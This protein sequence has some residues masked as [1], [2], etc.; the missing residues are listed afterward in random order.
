M[1]QEIEIRLS[2]HPDDLGKLAASALVRR[3]AQG[4]ATTRRLSTLYYDTP[5]FAFA[6]RGV[7]LRVRRQGKRFIQ[8]VKEKNAGA[9]LSERNEWE[10]PLPDARPDL[11]F[12]PDPDARER[13]MA[14][15]GEEI[16]EPKME[17]EIRRTTRRLK[18]DT[19]DEIE[20]AID[21][22]E[23]R[24]FANGGETLAISEIELELKGGSPLAL[25]DVVRALSESAALTVATESKSER[26]LRAIEGRKVAAVKA[27]RVTLAADATAEDAFRA[28]LLHCLRPIVQNVPAVAE[29]RSVE[30]LHQLRVGLRRL[31]AGFGAFG[32]AFENPVMQDLKQRAAEFARGFGETRDLD[33]FAVGLFLEIEDCAKGRVGI[34]E[35]R[36]HLD[37]LREQSWN[38]TAARAGSEAFTRFL[39]DLAAAAEAR[40]WREPADAA[41][42]V[43]FARPARDFA[44]EALDKRSRKARKRAK[45]LARLTTN[46][47][48]RLRIALK[49]LRYA[50][51]FFASLFPPKAVHIYQ[52]K[53]SD[54]QDVFG[55]LNDA[56]TAEDILRRILMRGM[57]E[58]DFALREGAAFTAGWHEARIG[59]AWKDARRRW[60]QLAKTEPFWAD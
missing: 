58:E 19:G 31:R 5:D 40:L 34:G 15:A 4:S 30:G 48:H 56:A 51:D 44:R 33:V 22:G 1:S 16:I 47:R 42:I 28:M 3:F 46:D 54:A 26:G 2:V 52:K 57:T 12:I 9:L 25:Y 59:P 24:T 37:A 23:I 53:L 36:L 14:L 50:A 41:A 35:L 32:D 43:V 55:A 27:G 60:K 20:F 21:R 29:G 8:S 38:R 13:L 11:R 39:L 6:R 7:S 45:H 17:T 49:R 10:A 18:T